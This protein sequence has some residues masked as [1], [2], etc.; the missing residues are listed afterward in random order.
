MCPNITNHSQAT[1]Q[2]HPLH[3]A[4]LFMMTSYTY[5]VT[6][7]AAKCEMTQL[8]AAYVNHVSS[9]T[10]ARV[11]SLAALSGLLITIFQNMLPIS[12]YNPNKLVPNPHML[13][14]TPL[15]SAFST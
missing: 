3:H 10:C 7:S 8:V 12:A 4:W 13:I 15:H 6:T 5:V 1:N 9:A 11:P 14:T 2:L